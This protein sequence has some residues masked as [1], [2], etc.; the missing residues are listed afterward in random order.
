MYV[1]QAGLNAEYEL[2]RRKY[3]TLSFKLGYVFEYIKNAGVNRDV[4]SGLGYSYNPTT[5]TVDDDGKYTTTK[6][7][8]PYKFNGSEYSTYEEMYS[9]AKEAAKAA[10]EEWISNL[11]DCTN[12]YLSVGFKYSY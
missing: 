6:N 5:T 12:H 2:S 7:E 10:K 3:G 9:A 11:Y 4:Y 8:K 1:L